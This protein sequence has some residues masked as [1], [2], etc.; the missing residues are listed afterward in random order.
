MTD[1]T[2]TAAMIAIGDE[3]LSG[4]TKDKNI[5]HLADVLTT[6][7]IELREVR[8]VSDDE[9]AIVAAINDLRPR[10]TYVFTSGGIGPTHDDITAD[11]VAKA[12]DLPCEH[13]AEA[14]DL[15]TRAYRTRGLEVT[16]ARMRM[17][18][19]PRGATHIH[20]P[21]STAPGFTVENVHV[22]AGVPSIFQAMLDTLLPDLES[23]AVVYSKAVDC[24]YGEGTIGE[25]LG[26]IQQAHPDT[27]IG[28]YPRFD[29]ESYSTQIVVRSR[30]EA[31]IDAA[32]ADV[33][34]MLD[35]I[36]AARVAR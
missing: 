26:T 15:L 7:G 33:T 28:S 12:F 18:R 10:F 22:M 34:A 9:D 8:I 3:L 13:D 4:R 36:R 16:D 24:P 31:A 29:G 17:A 32:V 20:N 30:N 25:E 6:A 23:G 14:V 1:K 35:R 11:A 27:V 19:M 21:V 2:V 5:A